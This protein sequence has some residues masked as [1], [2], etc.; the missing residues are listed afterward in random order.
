MDNKPP[1]LFRGAYDRVLRGLRRPVTLPVPNVGTDWSVVVPGGRMWRLVM[2][3]VSLVTSATVINRYP[4]ME[5]TDGS[6]AYTQVATATGQPA[7]STIVVNYCAWA[8]APNGGIASSFSL[9]AVP[10]VWIPGG[11]T[12]GSF[13]YNLQVGDQYGAPKLLIEERYDDDQDLLL[14]ESIEV[15]Q[16][17][18]ALNQPTPTR[19]GA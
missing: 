1:P 7:N 8:G 13:T 18:A 14:L 11:W 15:E 4:G 16:L 5:I 2:G 10:A 19:T 9:A 6:N 17:A 12:L 3:T